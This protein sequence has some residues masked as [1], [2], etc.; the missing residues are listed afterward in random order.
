M[1]TVVFLCLGCKHQ[2][3]TKDTK[4]EGGTKMHGPANA[5]TTD[6]VDVCTDVNFLSVYNKIHVKNIK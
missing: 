6:K 2:S 4:N 1:Y 3:R 5:W